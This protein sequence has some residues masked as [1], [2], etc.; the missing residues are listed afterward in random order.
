M[1]AYAAASYDGNAGL[2]TSL[3]AQ[4]LGTGYVGTV[5]NLE[6]TDN[7]PI[8]GVSELIGNN[9]RYIDLD[10]Y[11]ELTGTFDITF[12]WI[13][14]DAN[15]TGA[16]TAIMGNATTGIYLWD[17]DDITVTTATGTATFT[18][19]LLN[20]AQAKQVVI[21]IVRNSANL[22]TV[23][24]DAIPH[25]TP[26]TRAGTL[27]IET[28]GKADGVANEYMATNS[29]LQGVEITDSSGRLWDFPLTEGTGT[30]VVNASTTTN[31]LVWL[32]NSQIY[33][34]NI[35]DG[36]SPPDPVGRNGIIYESSGEVGGPS[37]GSNGSGYFIN[38]ASTDGW[39]YSV[40]PTSTYT[41]ANR[42]LHKDDALVIGSDGQGETFAGTGFA[43]L[44]GDYVHRAYWSASWPNDANGKIRAEMDRPGGLSLNYNR[45]TWLG[46]AI[47]IP[48]TA[49]GNSRINFTGASNF[50]MQFHPGDP[51]P[52][53]GIM[54]RNGEWSI[55]FGN[56]GTDSTCGAVVAGQWNKFVLNSNLSTGSDCYCKVWINADS[57]ADTPAYDRSGTAMPTSNANN[58]L[59][60][61]FGV[62]TG[63][64][65]NGGAN[66]DY[67]CYFF[68]EFRLGLANPPSGT[69]AGFDDV[70]PG[71]TI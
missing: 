26:V 66:Q 27:T 54:M 18:D 3:P 23:Y 65:S 58:S 68:D 69:G 14:V 38:G 49:N 29:A 2:I 41:T 31:K 48:D 56:L 50:V 25:A 16:K 55:G 45:D 19:A 33:S 71:G 22:V 5:S 51:G 30:A 37:G 70:N 43:P 20:K 42:I 60:W 64:I 61:K 44:V 47:W 53:V 9:A 57:D 21:R 67:A 10:Q 28:F 36:S 39:R 46:F 59:N 6:L 52:F 62:Y 15:S 13:R 32:T 40:T 63:Y 24:V 8:Q 35:T 11:I 34:N 17:N 7:A 1:P 4:V 12:N